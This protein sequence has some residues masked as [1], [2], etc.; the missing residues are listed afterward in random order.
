[1]ELLLD[2]VPLGGGNMRKIF[3]VVVVLL[4]V[5]EASV[6]AQETQRRLIVGSIEAKK[7][8]VEVVE[9]GRFWFEGCE[10]YHI[11][12]TSLSPSDIQTVRCKRL[13]A[14]T[15]PNTTQSRELFQQR[16]SLILDEQMVALDQG[17][18][19]RSMVIGVLAGAVSGVI[20]GFV[21]IGSKGVWAGM[22]VFGSIFGV[23]AGYLDY[24][25]L[26]KIGRSAGQILEGK[27]P[28]RLE[29]YENKTDSV[30]AIHHAMDVL[31]RSITVTMD[32]LQAQ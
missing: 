16:L 18:F 24:R 12:G 29:I 13:S 15:L 4:A 6:V 5:V 9:N 3:A 25:D 19:Q 30:A 8:L 17:M 31:L 27:L 14:A 2:T 11:T 21:M 28:Q 7:V 26:Q 23:I 20:T 22:A 1:M 10:W 32:S